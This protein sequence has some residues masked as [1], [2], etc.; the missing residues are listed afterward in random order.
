M[1][2]KLIFLALFISLGAL[3]VVW[4]SP[5][6]A[7]GGGSVAEPVWARM[8]QT[9]Q[10][11]CSYEV[12][13]P[14][15]IKD[16]N[17]GA[18]S[19]VYFDLM[20]RLGRDLNLK[21]VWAEEVGAADA[22]EGIR[23]GRTDLFCAPVTPT[24]A[25]AAIV[26]FTRSIGYDPFYLYVR[27]GDER[28]DGGYEKANDPQVLFLSLDGYVGATMTKEEFPKAQLKTLP[29]MTTDADVLLGL[30]TG[31]ADAAVCDSIAAHDFMKSNPGKIKQ[32]A[33]PPVRFPSIALALS[34]GEGRLRQMLNTALTHYLETGVMEKIYRVYDLDSEKLL[35]PARPFAVSPQE[36]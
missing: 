24:A 21:I 22:Y 32:V 29:N 5:P 31:K 17:S 12:W 33:G 20:E 2:D 26:D 13:P 8:T 4:L 16:P 9:R 19:G 35:R 14:L 30:S 36:E 23:T 34:L 18:L 28:F 15:L 25:R 10:I 11:R 6:R 7:R 1:K 3:G 27:A